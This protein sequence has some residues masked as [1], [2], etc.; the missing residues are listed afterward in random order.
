MLHLHWTWLSCGGSLPITPLTV[1]G[2]ISNREEFS[3]PELH[4]NIL[5]V[6]FGRP[7]P[8]TVHGYV[9]DFMQLC[10]WTKT[11]KFKD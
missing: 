11:P 2:G 6:K 3:Q 5:P 1:N 7:F 10:N 8:G 4:P 9:L